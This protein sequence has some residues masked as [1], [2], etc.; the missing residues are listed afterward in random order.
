MFPKVPV[1]TVLL[2]HPKVREVHEGHSKDKRLQRAGGLGC[3]R[4]YV[5]CEIQDLAEK[6]LMYYIY[7]YIFLSLSIYLSI[8][9]YIH[10]YTQRSDI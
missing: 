7:I 1:E 5:G 6:E 9:T 8:F 10:M 2:E 4:M 3:G